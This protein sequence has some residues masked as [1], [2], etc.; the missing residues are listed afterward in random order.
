MTPTLIETPC[1]L[2]G[3]MMNRGEFDCFHAWDLGEGYTVEYWRGIDNNG[4]VLRTLHDGHPV[5]FTH[6]KTPGEAIAALRLRGLTVPGV[7]A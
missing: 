1:G 5:S 7:P 2:R 6:Y 3:Q 4:A